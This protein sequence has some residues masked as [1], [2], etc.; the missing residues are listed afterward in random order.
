MVRET[1]RDL[2]ALDALVGGARTADRALAAFRA[3]P[4]TDRDAVAAA[5]ELG[6]VTGWLLFD[7]ARHTEARWVNR[8]SL[9]LSGAAGD[10][11]I[12]LLT[13]QNTALHEAYL[14]RPLT[15][16]RI[17]RRVLAGRLSPRLSALFRLREARALALA[18]DSAAVRRFAR[19]RALHSDGARDSDPAWAWWV[20]EPELAWHEALVRGHCG[21]WSAAVDGFHGALELVPETQ[22]RRRYLF[23]A[24]LAAAQVE[25]GARR[26]AG[27]PWTA[28]SLTSPPSAPR[29]RKRWCAG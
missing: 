28:C 24:S 29:A 22:V 7:A 14:G 9:R 21:D 20:D 15:A 8:A 6:E 13:A 16:L 23:L 3:A 11:A 1:I 10:R 25:A 19:V 27:R 18:G 12:A 5:G 26:D 17:A 2:V 4:R